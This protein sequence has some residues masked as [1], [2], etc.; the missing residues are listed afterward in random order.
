MDIRWIDELAAEI[1]GTRIFREAH[2][3]RRFTTGIRFGQGSAVAVFE[4]ASLLDFWKVLKASVAADCIIICQAANTG[5]T[6]GSTPD[7]DDY[8]REIVIISTLQLDTCM[9]LCDAQ[10]ALVL[11]GGTLYR[12]EEMLKPF[13][14]NPHSVIGSSCIGAS[15]IGGICNNSGGSLVKRGPAYTELALFARLT[16]QG[17]LELVNHLGIELGETPE[18]VLGNLDAGR[19][20]HDA[21]TLDGGLASDPEYIERVREIDQ[22]TP[23]RF[24]ADRRRLHEASGSA[25]K[26]AVFA[27]RVDTFDKPKAEQV[28]YVGTNDPEQLNDIRRRLLS[29]C[30][31]LPEMGEYMHQSWFDGADR[32]CKDTFLLIKYL[33]TDLLPRLYRI[34]AALDRWLE[35]VPGLP[36]RPADHLLQRL[37]AWWPDHLPKR[38]RDYRR[39]YEHHLILVGADTA[40]AEIRQVLHDVTRAG[41]TGAFFECSPKEGD[42]A[43]LHRLVAGGSPARYNLIHAKETN[44][45]VTFDVALPRNYS[46]WYEFLPKDLLDQCAAPYRGG[47]FMC[48]VFHWDF[49]VKSGVDPD[50]V[51]TRMM[52]LLDSIGAKYPAEHN[53]GHLYCAEHDHAAFYKELD[54]TNSF[55]AGVGKMAMPVDVM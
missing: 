13:G 15:V 24:N 16:E 6:G 25:G 18:E 3:I 7:G 55:N 5:V 23:S 40:I 52:S 33:G 53:V 36:N 38:M 35:K 43:L 51:K 44:G 27:V 49:V 48:H 28:F 31:E 17:E 4:P 9:P 34:K 22:P 8:D 26:L 42:A 37:A 39:A 41:D 11:A 50:A 12:L 46:N 19:F 20:D 21:A 32:Y 1:P 54:P 10:Q 2:H 45:M 14:K 30:K 29:H 47:H